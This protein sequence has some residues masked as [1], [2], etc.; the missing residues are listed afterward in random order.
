M[1]GKRSNL[2]DEYAARDINLSPLEMHLLVLNGTVKCTNWQHS[3]FTE[4][5]N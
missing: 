5:A 1:A 4:D 2:L 3:K